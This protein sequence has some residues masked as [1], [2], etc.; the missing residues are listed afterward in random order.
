MN[1][2][3]Q[4][5]DRLPVW[6]QRIYRE[7]LEYER[8]WEHKPDRDPASWWTPLSEVWDSF[9]D[10]EELP[11]DTEDEMPAPIQRVSAPDIASSGLKLKI[12]RQKLPNSQE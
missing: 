5:W 10:L 7:G 6:V 2:D 12:S 11:E 3:A 1:I 9:G 8:P 4:E